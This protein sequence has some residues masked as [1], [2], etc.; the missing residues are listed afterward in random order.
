[1]SIVYCNAPTHLHLQHLTPRQP[2]RFTPSTAIHNTL[3]LRQSITA[4]QV[5]SFLG[6]T[7]LCASGHAQLYWLC[8]V[9]Q[10]DMLNVYHSPGHLF[11]LFQLSLPALC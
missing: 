9:I 8:Y 6:K 4:Q 7:T 1:M 3:L 2:L 10:S 5:M 11:L